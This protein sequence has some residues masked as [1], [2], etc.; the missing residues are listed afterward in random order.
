MRYEGIVYRPPSEADSLLIQATIGCP[1]NKCTFCGMYK[2]KRFRIRKVSDIKADMES[3]RSYY[4][5][6][7]RS[8]FLPDGNTI[9]MKTEQLLDLLKYAHE[10][11]PNLERVTLYGSAKYIVKKTQEELN[12]LRKAGLKRIHTGM[13]S[14][15][16]ETLKCIR[17][18]TT[19]EEII[20]SGIMI[21]TAGIEQ[22]EYYMVGVAGKER[23]GEHARNS[24]KVLNAIDP[25]FIR[26]RTYV[27]QSNTPLGDLYEEG[28]FKLLTP[29]EAL[30]ET[31]E[32]IENL[33]GTGLL[34]SDHVSN[35][36]N[37]SGRLADDKSDM[38]AEIR[39]ALSWPEHRFRPEIIDGL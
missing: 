36:I 17:K 9:L 2:E 12:D 10:L 1:H 33:R 30:T 3:A 24:A 32:L 28:T 14:G 35:Y 7:I 38:L 29:H 11:F 26:L 4:G 16:N 27:P 13:E 21:K 34:L 25:E 39:S 5:S 23:S 15:D 6:W 31:L 18:G 22:S 8:L 37:V 19:S 20:R